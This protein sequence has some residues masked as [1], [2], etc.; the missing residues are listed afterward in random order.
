MHDKERFK[1]HFGPYRTPRFRYGA[2]VWDEWRGEVEIVGISAG[3]IPWPIGAIQARR[4]LVVYRGLAKAILV[5][6]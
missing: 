1:L 6:L 3:R 2:V 5:R 4:S